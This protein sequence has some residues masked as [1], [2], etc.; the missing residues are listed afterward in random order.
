MNFIDCVSIECFI[1]LSSPWVSF[2]FEVT[3]GH[4]VKVRWF[5]VLTALQCWVCIHAICVPLDR[6]IFNDADASSLDTT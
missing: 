6:F 1:T 2:L 4:S 3:C 5:C